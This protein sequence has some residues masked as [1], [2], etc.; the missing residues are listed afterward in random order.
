MQAM[1]GRAAG[2]LTLNSVRASATR[3]YVLIAWLH[4]P[5]AALVAISS[6]NG[7]AGPTVALALCALALNVAALT[8]RDGLAL[9]SFAAI[10]LT[11]API[12]FVYASRG[13]VDSWQIDYHM[14]FFAVYAML[15]G[16][17]DWRPIA[18]AAALTAGHHLLL[19]LIDP[20]AVFPEE[21]LARVALHAICVLAE[22]SVLFWATRT[23]ARLFGRVDELI[24]TTAKVT[25]DAIA[26]EM[27]EN[28]RLRARIAALS[29]N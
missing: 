22:C 28:E 15:I 7:W 25:A 24:D 10:V 9:R 12:A 16:Y 20:T 5:A 17:V 18:V 3:L 27:H 4:V 14:Y 23:I 1:L 6:H 21:G 26:A 19:D 11:A 29:A 13:G 8:L 2:P